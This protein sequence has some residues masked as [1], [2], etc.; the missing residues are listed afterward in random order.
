MSNLMD[1]AGQEK[2]RQ[3]HKVKNSTMLTMIE[4]YR[5]SGGMWQG[6]Q[7]QPRGGILRGTERWAGRHFAENQ[8]AK[9]QLAES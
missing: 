8:F 4:E 3:T 9:S 6:H 2:G 7:K 1:L 5:T